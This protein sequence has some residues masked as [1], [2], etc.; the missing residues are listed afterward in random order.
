MGKSAKSAPAKGD[1]SL[2]VKGGGG[3]VQ[4]YKP[5]PKYSS[6]K[7]EGECNKS[8]IVNLMYPDGTCYGWAFH[9]FYDA[10]E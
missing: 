3:P 8:K 5:S 9:N 7:K 4:K 1:I 10:K 6:P 2:S